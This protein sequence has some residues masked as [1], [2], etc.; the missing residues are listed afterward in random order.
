M[1]MRVM[2][3]VLEDDRVLLF[4]D[5]ESYHVLASLKQAETIHTGDIVSYEPCGYNFGWL[6]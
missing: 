5:D 4:N 3:I 2:R 1:K 6:E